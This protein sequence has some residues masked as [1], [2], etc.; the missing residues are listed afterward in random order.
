MAM[1][2]MNDWHLNYEKWLDKDL[3]LMTL[4]TGWKERSSKNG[5]SIWQQPFS[6]DKNDLFKWSIPDVAAG[7]NVVFDVFVN[8]M[9]D[10]HHYW[11][12]EYTGGFMVKQ[13]DENTQIV[14]Q[15]FNP[16]I[17]LISKRDLLYIQW[18]RK[19]DDATIQTSFRSIVLDEMPVPNG[20]ER[21]DW[22]GAHLFRANADSTSQ[23]TLI[24]RE[25]QGG[26]F[27]SFMMNKVMP[28][29]LTLQVESIISFFKKGGTKAHAKLAAEKNTALKMRPAQ[30]TIHHKQIQSV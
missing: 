20:Y 13:V 8:K 18:W 22:W 9:I 1:I 5:I 16:G 4:G 25:N 28:K 15:Q 17:P 10:Y 30:T 14:Y 3:G 6:D 11:T 2:T 23:L 7:H 21:I 26:R 24:D 19:I 27:P 12:A 29:Y